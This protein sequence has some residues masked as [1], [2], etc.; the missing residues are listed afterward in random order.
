MSYFHYQQENLYCEANKL[1]DLTR[2]IPTPFYVY[3]QNGLITNYE[4]IAA[5]FS[6][7]PHTICFAL[8]ANSNLTLLRLLAQR[9]CGADVVSGGELYLALK[10][11]F[12]PEKIVFAGVGKR[13][14]EIKFAIETGIAALNVESPHELE[15]VN[16]LATEVGKKVNIALRINPDVDVHGHPHIS[17]GS[18]FNKFGIDWEVVPE[19]YAMALKTKPMLRM[20]G[21]HTHIGSMIFNM[22]YYQAAALRLKVLVEKL[23]QLGAPI[24]H[25]DIGGGL[26]INY[27]Q[28]LTMMVDGVLK[29]E[30]PS[31]EPQGLTAMIL[32]I[33]EPLKCELFFEPGRSI[34]ANT[35]ALVT[36]V[37]FAKQTRE[38]H[39]FSVDTG[40]HHLL[41][42]AL[43]GAYHEIVPLRQHTEKF[44]KADI[45][46]PICE[47]TDVL[48]KDRMLP[49]VTRGEYLAIMTAG[50]YGFSLA[51][52]YNGQPLPAE[53]LINGSDHQIIRQRQRYDDLLLQMA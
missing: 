47:S 21:I 50:A 45:V 44:I 39:F 20:M 51:S 23:R 26:G 38:K 5:A 35:G 12:K 15:V 8:K 3:S 2:E 22:E 19:I 37:L 43:Y 41:R 52:N 27:Q 6:G 34:V 53:I 16:Q 28:P 42:P 13:D 49:V 32:P 31:P 30:I 17:T 24:E 4:K 36:Q 9:G 48:A 46:G 7:T 29:P 1:I 18:A 14:D 33:L 25:I 11:G 40:M 10:A